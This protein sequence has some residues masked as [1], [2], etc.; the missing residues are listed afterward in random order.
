[1]LAAERVTLSS[2]TPPACSSS[3]RAPPRMFIAERLA[4]PCRARRPTPPRAVVDAPLSQRTQSRST[5]RAWSPPTAS[6]A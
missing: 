4:A 2:C 6:R 3:S 5:P 1:V